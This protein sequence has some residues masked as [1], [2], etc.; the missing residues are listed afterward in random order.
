MIK[1]ISAIAAAAVMAATMSIAAYAT[2]YE[3]AVQAA[4][5]AGVQSNNVQELDNF[6]QVHKDC[7][8]SAQYDEMIADLN[9]IRDTY[10][11]PYCKG[12]AKM[13]VDKAPAD[14]TEADK[15][16]VGR[17]WTED[18]KKAITDDLVNLGKRYGVTITVTNIDKAH[19]AV[20][21]EHP[22]GND[23]NNSNSSKK[24][25]SN[26]SKSGGS[27]VTTQTDK[28]VADT[29]AGETETSNTAAAVAA[30]ALAAAGLGVVVMAK[31]NR[32]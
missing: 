19:Y 22:H 21:A 14:L 8:T 6:L 10:V 31:K 27:G 9:N 11:A 29:G 16:L 1:K 12:G 30:V 5:D 17:N 20:A 28:P 7:F 24:D 15:I 3:D 18:E 26:S 4:K 13:V 32:A 2:T 25:G 23:S